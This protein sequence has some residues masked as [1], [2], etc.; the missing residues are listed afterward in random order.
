MTVFLED[1]NSAQEVVDKT[2]IVEDERKTVLKTL[3]VKPGVKYVLVEGVDGLFSVVV[4]PED[5]DK[6]LKAAADPKQHEG[7]AR[8]DA[9]RFCAQHKGTV[10]LFQCGRVLENLV[11]EGHVVNELQLGEV[12]LQP[13]K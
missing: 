7:I 5:V 2:F 10:V 12:E 13:K 3:V 4:N 11:E 8:Q 9:E 1:R 6:A